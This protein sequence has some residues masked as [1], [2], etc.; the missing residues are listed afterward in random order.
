MEVEVDQRTISG[1][2]I[3]IT[4]SLGLLLSLDDNR[5]MNKVKLVKLIW[6]ADRYHLRKYG[7]TV[8]DT[9]YYA[10]PH[11]PVSSLTL[12]VIDNDE[13]AL[14]AEDI[15]FIA[16]HITPW[17]EDINEVVLYND[18][19]NDYLSETDLEALNFAWS[20]FGDKE[21]FDLADNITHQYPEWSKFR[22]HF[23]VNNERSR[24]LIDLDDFFENP[25]EDQYFVLDTN[26]LTASQEIYKQNSADAKLLS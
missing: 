23:D 3:K 13:V 12:D 10:M 11:G 5:L 2:I 15:E 21:P 8:T 20:T 22:E 1:E 14:Y 4:Q 16:N 26:V 6:A 7:R 9:E 24:K 19:E 18:T 17:K 25:S